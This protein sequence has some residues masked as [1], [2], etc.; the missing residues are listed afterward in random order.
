MPDDPQKTQ[1]IIF[2]FGAGASVDAGIPDTYKF[3]DD[4]KAKL[5]S[6]TDTDASLRKELLFSILN[7]RKEFN[8]KVFG[9]EKSRVDV[10]QLLE[11]VN[12]LIDSDTDISLYSHDSTIF[13][14]FDGQKKNHLRGLKKELE[15][16]VREAVIVREERKL[17]YLKELFKF[18]FPIEIY[19]VNYDTCIEQL[20]YVNHL[21]YADGF[22]ITWD[23]QNFE[24]DFDVKHYK[25]HG[26]AIWY[27]NRRT[28]ECVKIPVQ[29]FSNGKPTKLQ[30]IYGEEV[31]PLLVYP[32]QKMEYVEPLTE[33]QLMFK[34]RIMNK[35]TRIL[36]IVGYS[37]RDNYIIHMLWDAARKNE[38][39]YVLIVNPDAQ[40]LF[41][42]RLRFINRTEGDRSRIW[43]RVV[44][45][46]YPFSTAIYQLSDHYVRQLQNVSFW[47]KNNLNEERVGGQTN[48]VGLL[49]MC[50]ECEF[51]EKAEQILEE[52]IRRDWTEITGDNFDS[53][54]KIILSA[55]ALLHSVIA[56][57]AFVDRWLK[58]LN[59]SAGFLNVERLCLSADA[60][61]FEMNL[62]MNV[63]ELSSFKTL[64]DRWIDPII[65]EKNYKLALLGPVFKDKL[66]RTEKSFS[67]LKEFRNYLIQFSGKVLWEKYL[68][69][70]GSM[71][72]TRRMPELL[73][74]LSN[75]QRFTEIEEMVL[76]LEKKEL[77]KIL[78][79]KTLQ[80]ELGVCNT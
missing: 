43:D 33:L 6:F 16:F 14:H 70:R 60:R 56:Q 30:L 7:M 64:N 40:N 24:A 49:I 8:E 51:L 79:G 25:L 22:N 26:S 37:F 68:S 78:G 69:I 13:D 31:E 75:K 35:E 72:E 3:V 66:N 21:R 61:G 55:K 10:E 34:E 65:A 58:R 53:Q 73:K 59:D 45:L 57:D 36:V 39:L 74:D 54:H 15:D 67:H 44:C 28:K 63:G 20:C 52:K 42:N 12:R 62:E 38:D 17:E 11:T 4:F 19:S 48:W 46:P 80:F 50:I 5:E 29:A 9:K 23:A 76:E 77:T 47:W 1:P 41:E 18:S 27:E 2:F 71:A 32:A